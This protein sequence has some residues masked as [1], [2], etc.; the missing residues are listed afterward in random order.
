[1][2]LTRPIVQPFDDSHIALVTTFADQAVIAIQNAKLFEDVQARTR[3][4]QESLQQQTATSEVLQV[5]SSTPGELQPVFQAMLE[6]ATR[7]CGANFGTMTRYDGDNFE[8]VAFHNVPPAFTRL[9][10]DKPF[11]PHPRGLLSELARTRQVV[12]IDDLRKGAAYLDGDPVSVAF[13][14]IAG[15]RTVVNVPMLKNA[16][17][18]GAI[19]I[20]RMEVRPFT[21]KQIELMQTFAD[22][23]VIAIENARLLTEQREA[24][25]RQTASAEVLQVINSSPGDLAPVFETILEKA[26]S[27][28]AVAHGTLLLYDGEKFRAVAVRGFPEAFAAR[29]RQGFIP[30]PNLPH[31]RLLEGARFVQ[32]TDWAEIDDPIARASLEAGVR[33]TLFIPLRREGVLIGYIA[34]SRAEVRPFTEKEIALLEGFAAQ[35]V[36]AM[37]NAR[38]L[39]ETKESLEQ[40]TATADVLKTISRSTVDLKTVLDALVETAARLCHADQT[41]MFR[42]QTDGLHY[43]IASYGLSEEG[44][45]YVETHPFAPDRGTTS[46]RVALER[47][48]I[49]IPDVLADSDYTYTEGQRLT[50]FRTLLGLPLLREDKLIGVF[51]IGRSRVDPF[52]D[53]EIELATTFADQAVIAIENA[54]LFEE[55]RDRQADLARSVDELTATSDVLKIISRSTVELETVLGTLVE[56]AA[57]LCRADQ[58]QMFRRQDDGYH[59][60]AFHGASPEFKEWLSRNP[61]PRTGRG[62]AVARAAAERRTVHIADVMTDPEYS[63]PEGRRVGGYRTVLAVPLLR[64]DTEIGFFSLLR[65][66]VAPFSDKEIELAT[67]FADQAVIAIENARL[68]DELRDRQAEL[69]VTFDNMG[70]GVV[71]FDAEARL[72]AWNRNFQE[73]LELPDAFLAGRPSFAEFFRYLAE[74][75]EYSADL[76]AQ[77]S[78]TIDDP[79]QELRLERTRPDGRVIEVR[80]NPVPGGGFV[81]IYADIT[82]R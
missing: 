56:T 14:D 9:R 7:V 80:R 66:H 42:R 20:R 49:H 68:F 19:S 72:T 59:V 6:N 23:A 82:E 79:S 69:R 63:L 21:D 50:G 76:E 26:H 35:A 46:G 77:L 53:K 45:I 54:R 78:R 62:T 27:L 16:E 48:P 60:V 10:K 55:L 73:M 32:V 28:C 65:A 3:D 58:T 2:V 15:A 71:M 17:L 39:N 34:A 36:I 5:I 8:N 1:M 22:Q 52:T 41:Y 33:T 11:R 43:M 61:L 37:E 64:G 31:R 40:Q 67:T 57:R 13:A 70:D 30:G 12:T 81:L 51:V 29:L 75:G 47:R 4:L 38:L 44:R 24:L 25:E 74:R 18:I